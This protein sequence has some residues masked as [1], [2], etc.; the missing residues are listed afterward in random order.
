MKNNLSSAEFV[1]YAL[2]DPRNSQIFYIGSSTDVLGRYRSHV[3]AAIAG[4]YGPRPTRIRAILKE[5]AIPQ[6]KTLRKVIGE[7]VARL[8]E[9]EEM[10]KH[11]STITNQ[12]YPISSKRANKPHTFKPAKRGSLP[13]DT[14]DSNLSA[15]TA[16]ATEETIMTARRMALKEGKSLRVWAG[17]VIAEAL[18]KTK[19]RKP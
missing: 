12:A 4:Q 18:S 6:Y 13:C 19:L 15:I 1:V 10:E 8:A 9:L 11:N 5:A 3:T 2:I 17:D 14:S 16:N 7:K